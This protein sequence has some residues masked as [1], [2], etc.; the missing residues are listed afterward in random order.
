MTWDR[1]P[2]DAAV[3]GALVAAVA[4]LLLF[5]CALGLRAA[6]ARGKRQLA[7]LREKWWPVFAE[8]V[9]SEQFADDAVLP[10]VRAGQKKVL[11]REWSRFRNIVQGQATISLNALAE[12]LGLLMLA[13]RRLRRRSINDRLLAMRV[14]GQIRDRASWDAIDALVEDPNIA[15]SMTAAT[16]L[17]EIDPDRAI[18]RIVPLIAR[19]VRWPRNQVG[20][21]LSHAGPDIVS[22]RL[23][24]EIADA[25]DGEAVRLLQFIEAAYPGDINALAERLL[26]TRENPALLSAALKA[27]SG[28]ICPERVAELARHDVW[29]VRM[30][31]AALLGRAGKPD[32]LAAL[33]PLLSDAEWWVRYRT[34]QAIVASPYIGPQALR[35][36]AAR[37]TDRFARDIL[38]QAMAEKGLA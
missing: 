31:A 38:Q 29:Y 9:M 23:C 15:V 20:R 13:R 14:L 4:V 8:V 37:Q 25:T 24:R 5:A 17:A 19:F 22:T 28:R 35:R 32:D 6:H 3:T 26:K 36:I 33:E 27:A 16:A 12:K 1:L 11:L 30:Q 18:P 10:A 7:L 34:A 2:D 21:I